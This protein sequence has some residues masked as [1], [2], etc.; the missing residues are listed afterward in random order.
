MS[1]SRVLYVTT[2]RTNRRRRCLDYL[3]GVCVQ[4]GTTKGLE[5]DHIDPATKSISISD[6]ITA[7]WSWDKILSELVKCQLLCH[8]HHR[9]K[10]LRSR[11]WNHGTLN[12]YQKKGCRCTA[13]TQRYAQHMEERQ[14][15][16]GR[17]ITT[18]WKPRP[19]RE[20]EHGTYAMYRSGCHCPLC[21][22]ANAARILAQRRSKKTMVF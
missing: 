22:K 15:R 6:A 10:T 3:G 21:R 17:Q 8:D 2:Y 18:P 11:N 9:A 19:T 20:R 7:C 14:R 13:C 16:R 1:A 4:C 5:F 12:G